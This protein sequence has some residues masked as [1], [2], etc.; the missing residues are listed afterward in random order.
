MYPVTMPAIPITA[1]SRQIT[2][3]FLVWPSALVSTVGSATARL[4]PNATRIAVSGA[5]SD[6]FS[7]KYITG[8][9]INPPPISRS[10]DVHPA[11]NPVAISRQNKTGSISSHLTG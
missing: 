6:I 1:A 2:F 5:T 7:T 4:V 11:N 10:P 8:A 9:K 3:P